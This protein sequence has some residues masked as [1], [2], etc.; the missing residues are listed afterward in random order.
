MADTKNVDF[1]VEFYNNSK[2]IKFAVNTDLTFI[3]P[4]MYLICGL[5]FGK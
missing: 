3:Y 5:Y 4:V 1:S 2:S